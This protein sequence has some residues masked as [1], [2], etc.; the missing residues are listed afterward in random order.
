MK[1]IIAFLLLSIGLAWAEEPIRVVSL[2]TVLTDVARNV[3]GDHVQVAGIVKPGIDPHEFEPSPGD[4][5]QIE[6]ADLVLA[7]GK[8]IEGYLAKLEKISGSASR[9][10]DV[11]KSIPSLSMKAEEGDQIVEDPH[12][13]HSIENVRTAARIVRDAFVQRAPKQS[14]HFN[15]QWQ[16]YDEKLEA[17]EHWAALEVAQLPRNKRKLVTSH[18]AFQYFA[19]DFGFTVYPIEGINTTDQPSSQKVARLIALIKAEGVKSIFFENIEN[20]KVVTEIVRETGAKLGGSLYADG[21]GEGDASTYEG[22]MRH[23]LTTIVEGLK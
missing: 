8:G 7:S 5:Q 11:G 14:D 9:F 19:R 17:L 16:S 23:N 2:S 4:I 20:P 1:K 3:G 13:W 21:L 22:M 10:I 12:W 18:D 6:K 15:R